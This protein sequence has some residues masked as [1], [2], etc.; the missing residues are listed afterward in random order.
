MPIVEELK[1][2]LPHGKAHCC[3]T[4][5]ES[6]FV[7]PVVYSMLFYSFQIHRWPKLLLSLLET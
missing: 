7:K 2:R 3:H 6:F 5:G 1:L 4:W